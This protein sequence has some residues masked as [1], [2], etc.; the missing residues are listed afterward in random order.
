MIHA[1]DST[2]IGWSANSA[3]PSQAPALP[4]QRANYSRW[5]AGTLTL[6]YLLVAAHIAHWRITGKTLAP[7]ELNEVMY[8]LELGIVTAGFIFM[9]V[10]AFSVAIFGRFFCS[11]GCHILA[12]EDLCAWLLKKLRIRP[13]PIRS[14]MLLF[15]PPSRHDQVKEALADLIHVPFDIEPSGSRIIFYDPENDYSAEDALNRPRPVFREL[16]EIE[17][18]PGDPWADDP[19]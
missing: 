8:T 17:S 16:A 11:W 7:L 18:A 10:A 15:V 14:R 9:V 13:K 1:T 2:W 19:Q 12:L 6:V 5:R 4:G 3:A